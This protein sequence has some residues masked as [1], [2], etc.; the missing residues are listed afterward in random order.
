MK[1]RCLSLLLILSFLISL[2][3]AITVKA[4]ATSITDDPLMNLSTPKDY[5]SASTENPY[6]YGKDE[7]FLLS[8]ENELLLYQTFDTSSTSARSW[9]TW[10]DNFNTGS[11]S[12]SD[13]TLP[14]TSTGQLNIGSSAYNEL[15]SFTTNGSYNTTNSYSYVKAV[16]FDPTGS[17]RDDYVA[18]VGFDAAKGSVVAWVSSTTAQGNTVSPVL[19]IGDAK[20]LTTSSIYEYTANNFFGITAGRYTANAT[21]DTAIIYAPL[22]NGS[23]GLFELKYNS[24]YN[25]ASLSSYS[26]SQLALHTNYTSGYGIEMAKTGKYYNK[27]CVALGSGD[28]NGDGTDDLAVLSYIDRAS[29][30]TSAGI[31]YDELPYDYYTPMICAVYGSSG[32]IL[33]SSTFQSRYAKAYVRSGA[34]AVAKEGDRPTF[35]TMAS[36]GLSV[37]DLDGDGDDDVVV[38]GYSNTVTTNS[39]NDGSVYEAFAIDSSKI[40][41][42]SFG[43]VVS[44]STQVFRLMASNTLTSNAWTAGSTSVGVWPKTDDVWQQMAVQCVAINGGAA[45]QNV[46]IS[47]TL[48]TAKGG[49]LTEAYTPTY[50]KEVDGGAGSNSIS[51]NY[52]QSVT[53]GNFD[54][55]E[56]GREQVVFVIGLKVSTFQMYYFKLGMIGG[57][58][59]NDTDSNSDGVYESLG[60]VGRYF[61]TD[62]D[63]NSYV[64]SNKGGDYDDGLNCCVV[65]IDRDSDG[66][67]A[68]YSRVAY[69][70]A[71]PVVLAVLQ[72]APYF[73][74]LGTYDDFSGETEYGFTQ[75]YSFDQSTTDSLS[76]SVGVAAE[77]TFK[78]VKVS[79]E[80][81]YSHSWNWSF[82]QEQTTSYSAT[83]TTGATDSV[84]LYRTPY[85]IYSYDVWIPASG[86]TAG[87]WS[88]D[89]LAINIPHEPTYVEKTV[90][91][92][93]TFV[94]EYNTYAAKLNTNKPA[95]SQIQ[96][97]K[98]LSDDYLGH[99]GDPF[100]YRHE[101]FSASENLSLAS[102]GLSYADG[103]QQSSYS[104]GSSTTTGFEETNGGY[105]GLT[106][107]GGAQGDSVEFWAGVAV[108]LDY[109]HGYGEYSTTAKSTDT[110][111]TVANISPTAMKA[112][113]IPES[114]YKAYGFTWTFGKWEKDLGGSFGSAPLLGYCVQ[115]LTAPCAPPVLTN[116][117]PLNSTSGTV[118]WTAPTDTTRPY[119]GYNLY[120]VS[121][122]TYT[123]LNSEPL[124]KN[125]LSYTLKNLASD[126]TYTFVATTV[127]SAVTLSGGGIQESPWSNE[128]TMT[129]SK[130]AFLLQFS[131]S[132]AGTATV[133][134]TFEGSKEAV[135]GSY[136]QQGTLLNITAK[137]IPGY[138]VT[139]YRRIGVTSVDYSLTRGSTASFEATLS[140]NTQYVI[141]TQRVSGVVNYSA[142][143]ESYGSVT[144]TVGGI[145]FMSGDTAKTTVVL[146]AQPASSY[147]L[148]GWQISIDGG[149]TTTVAASGN[150]LNFE[151][152]G[153]INNVVAVFRP[154]SYNTADITVLTSPRGNIS[155]QDADG[156]ILTP[157]EGV[158]TVTRGAQL[159]F[160]ATSASGYSFD[161]W[162]GSLSDSGTTNPV[163]VTVTGD[164]TISAS[165]FAPTTRSM[166]YTVYDDSGSTPVASSTAGSLRALQ[167]GIAFS[168]GEDFLPN[169]ED[170]EFTATPAIGYVFDH[171]VENGIRLSEAG[172][173]V[174]VPTLNRS[175]T[176]EAHFVKQPTITTSSLANATVAHNYSQTLAGSGPSDSAWSIVSGSLPDGLTLNAT[177]GLISGSAITVGYF[178]FTVQYGSASHALSAQKQL[179]ILVD[180]FIP[181]TSLTYNGPTEME[182]GS[183]I[184]LSA[185][186]SPATASTREITWTFGSYTLT[187]TYNTPAI[188]ENLLHAEGVGT[189]EVIGTLKGGGNDGK[190]V[191]CT[192]T[193]TVKEA[194]VPVEGITGVKT[195]YYYKTTSMTLI[196][197]GDAT[198]SNENATNKTISWEIISDFT[199][200]VNSDSQPKVPKSLLTTMT[201]DEATEAYGSRT[202]NTSQ[203]SGALDSAVVKATVKD[204]LA[205]GKDYVQYYVISVC[206]YGFDGTAPTAV[207]PAPT[208][209]VSVGVAT[210]LPLRAFTISGRSDG[211]VEDTEASKANPYFNITWSIE[212]GSTAGAVITT[213]PY[214][215]TYNNT[216]YTTLRYVLTALS[217]GTIKLK[218]T[219]EHG[220]YELGT[221]KE[222]N[223]IFSVT[224]NAATTGLLSMGLYSS[225]GEVRFT[226]NRSIFNPAIHQYTATVDPNVEYV[227]VG[228]NAS[229]GTAITVNG[230]SV[231]INA[232]GDGSSAPISLKYGD[233][234][235]TVVAGSQTYTITVTRKAVDIQDI[236]GIPTTL[237][238]G[239]AL[240]GLPMITPYG[241]YYS[242]L[243][244]SVESPGT[245]GLT[246]GSLGSLPLKSAL[247]PTKTGNFII[248]ITATGSSNNFKKFFAVTVYDD[249]IN[250]MVAAPTASP[251]SGIYT[252]TKSVTLSAEEGTEIYYT[253]N[254]SVP[255]TE[256]TKYT[257][258][259]TVSDST[260]LRAVAIKNSVSSAIAEEQY[261]ITSPLP[262]APAITTDSL[263]NGTVGTAYSA[264]LA[265]T[266]TAPITW[267]VTTGTLPAGLSL[268]TA[269]VI[270]GT[271][272][273][274][275][276]STFS[277]Q[278]QNTIGSD[279]KSLSITV[280]SAPVTAY[281]VTVIG[282]YAGISGAGQYTADEIVTIHAGT[283]SGYTF[284]GWSSPTVSF[285]SAFSASTT[286]VMPAQ[287]V[288]VVANWTSE[289]VITT[290][291]ED[292][293]SN[294][295]IVIVDGIRYSIGNTETTGSTTVVSADQAELTRYIGDADS[296]SEV[297]VPI[298]SNQNVA[299]S[300]TV[301]NIE[302]MAKKDMTL[303]VR[304]G[305][306]E[307]SMPATA[308]DTD[309][310][311]SA[312]GTHNS[313][314]V[315]FRVTIR[316]LSRSSVPNVNLV[317]DPLSFEVSA[318]YG[319]RTTVVDRFSSY[320]TRTVPLTAA[321]A[322]V[323]TTAVAVDADGTLRQIP[324][325]VITEGKNSRAV[326]YSLTNSV[327]AL[328]SRSSSFS[329][330]SGKWYSDVAVEMA[331]RGIVTGYADNTFRGGSDI[332]RA[333]FA[334]ILIRALGLPA[335]GDAS[336]FRDVSSSAW[337]YGA[338]GTAYEYGL[339]NGKSAA[340]FDPLSKITR[341][342]AMTMIG[343]ASKLIGWAG[344]TSS[345]DGFRD[346]S[347]VS[348]WAMNAAQWSVGSSILVG[349]HNSI[350][351]LRNI[352]RAETA[353]VILRL[354]QKSGL[355]DVRSAV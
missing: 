295:S 150:T 298:E 154:E 55:N 35:T 87:H 120:S 135:S 93:N 24:Q 81:G 324:T 70:Y 348:A 75:E 344:T 255:S 29:G 204:G 6:G 291:S 313:S 213:V 73:G 229:A 77:V 327:Y 279:T 210:D 136:Y 38:A 193:I 9:T 130:A 307:Y 113:G 198:V 168:S 292:T 334:A 290:P 134:A 3:P 127:N 158:L 249:T 251:A 349:E 283:R 119:T 273:T 30:T 230:S 152:V 312:L 289:G 208:T 253:T 262:T 149:S 156:D 74:E 302:S 297:I 336:V 337:Y 211:D 63:G 110:A 25:Y 49:S 354:L 186:V 106:V 166:T 220:E 177:T 195:S 278:A 65:A 261:T 23:F 32:S 326:I 296:A 252:E 161:L 218:G 194:F 203:N 219:V 51:V 167:N 223:K 227:S 328:I 350:Y 109:E 270:S 216:S 238:L 96:M 224:A 157:T 299:A 45:A 181:A 104:Y 276:T 275:G 121:N 228:L 332:T 301:A 263:A 84:V 232:A 146:T 256:S 347:Q 318:L 335:D 44:N 315:E 114:V 323:T 83:F 281:T 139:G 11:V 260:Q 173:I 191:S 33:D 40:Y 31:D 300:L 13:A 107:Q 10:Y 159:T 254:G 18:Y 246:K 309:A 118:T 60:T 196:T 284:S 5:N 46:F 333:E 7:N 59:Y 265:A 352:T 179:S 90:D 264:T 310:L 69:A 314:S 226:G 98:K 239:E 128:L 151:P 102:M 53:A 125:T 338:V 78:H 131:S 235:I 185:A 339:V 85:F 160:T 82:E 322:A 1:K 115:N 71:D 304:D 95:K 189:V 190:D 16:A 225:G 80:A 36:A 267:S 272:T 164:M 129:T 39:L 79:V 303:I 137:A 234:T 330:A 100:S 212:S 308:V 99:E 340:M 345:L 26:A 183:Q 108:S 169:T 311:L 201:S 116:V 28:L 66:L 346:A 188:A 147:V 266:G 329:D 320:V 317:V 2:L 41:S 287:N 199:K 67:L 259:I 182:S 174:K 142:N 14:S 126:T 247:Q 175:Y 178:V 94:D 62:I 343:R 112:N 68:R 58:E 248:S 325:N 286:F 27:L 306:V 197:L 221:Y 72:A 140:E 133:T 215:Y 274:A 205:V 294:K 47:G 170:F 143:S 200:F 50:F 88:E 89:S 316:T 237:K 187:P 233:N 145:T 91:D 111:G 258:P 34:P 280:A 282:S 117:V 172:A 20:W 4:Q 97:L 176:I 132:P 257:S 236:T 19:T 144:A 57:C 105:F 8:A 242:S 15:G 61:S 103:A 243:D 355:V 245:T 331:S 52:I 342:E 138:V 288:F 148:T 48:Y 86:S 171:W 155:I 64:V 12:A 54:G 101:S 163:I 42:Q 209:P 268:S 271:P 293:G 22:D 244:M 184:K 241:A 37:G 162:T 56:G 305:D 222:V 165:Y 351:P 277:V 250:T 321:E 180:A 17:G 153:S 285:A 123:K 43:C 217:A 206:Y 207:I 269:G 92:Y 240:D 202:F 21:G 124:S 341:Q 76:L 141:L 319:G 231:T 353:T 192:Q 122:G 214:T